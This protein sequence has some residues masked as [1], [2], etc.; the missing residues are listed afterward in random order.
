M[1]TMRRY[2]KYTISLVLWLC[3]SPTSGI[4]NCPFPGAAFPKPTNLASSPTIQAALKNVTAAFETYDR[5]PANNPNTTSWSLQIFS[6]SSDEPLWEHYHTAQNLLGEDGSGNVTVGPDTIY[7][8]GSLTKIF[9]ILTFLAEAGDTYWNDPVTKYVPELQVLAARAMADPVMYVDWSSVT[10]GGLASHMA[11]ITRDY[12]LQ[13]EL[14]QE[15]NQTV[16][17][18]QGF[19]PAPWTMV[20]FCGEVVP[21]NRTQVFA[22]LAIVPPSFV[23]SHTPG[24][25][26]L[27]YQLLAY[28]LEAITGKKFATMLKSD[29]LGKLGLEHTYY[30]QTPPD[31]LGVIPPGNEAGWNFSLGEANP[32]GGMYS[33]IADLS[34][35][36]RAIFRNTL[37]TP[38]QT[39]RWLKPAATTAEIYEG[40]SYPWGYRRIPLGAPGSGLANRIVD[41]YNKAGSINKYASLMVLLPDYEVGF[42][43]LLAGG[44]GGNANWNMADAIG[45]VLLPALEAAARE[46]ADGRYAGTYAANTGT[47]TDGLSINSSLVLSTDPSKP[48]LGVDRW[49]SNGT[50]MIPVAIRYTLNYNVTGPSIRLF[51]TGLESTSSSGGKKIIAF[52]AMI[53]NTATPDRG[54]RMFSTNCGTWVSQSVAVYADYPLDQFVFTIGE[55]GRA[56]SVV[57][58]ALR[59]PLLREGS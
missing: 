2:V 45:P 13:G 24:Y 1:A 4:P 55:D 34:T 35:L 59:T 39:R 23:P 42:D 7:R 14:T 22:G 56:E 15:H 53:E 32:T 21:C 44:W 33:S 5:D 27:G 54:D 50:D 9:T 25:S 57:P 16:L 17:M 48:G 36:G 43:A 38:A 28:A 51:P 26:N 18:S 29:V 20:P 47:G 40:V 31:E 58:L 10:L 8:L 37:L 30:D 46:E 3:A 49:V 41:A 12:A 6:A 19:P 52:K 11:G